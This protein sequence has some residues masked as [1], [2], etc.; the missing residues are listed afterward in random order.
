MPENK[1]LG[2]DFSASV[3][4]LLEVVPFSCYYQKIW[5]LALRTRVESGTHAN[6][7]SLPVLRYCFHRNH[8]V[9][10]VYSRGDHDM[11]LH[12]V[13]T[14]Y[15]GSAGRGLQALKLAHLYLISD[16]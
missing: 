7:L 15:R 3:S 2:A 14:H 8:Y 11:R 6:P 1:E 10:S 5:M 16:D 9:P 12:T 4:P 13:G